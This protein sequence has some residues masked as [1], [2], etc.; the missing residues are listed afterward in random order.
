MKRENKVT[1][2]E[3]II[4]FTAFGVGYTASVYV[5]RY[6]GTV[7]STVNMGESPAPDLGEFVSRYKGL[8]YK[9]AKDTAIF[10]EVALAQMYVEASDGQGNFGKGILALNANNYFG[11]KADANWR[12][13]VYIATDSAGNAGQHWRQYASPEDSI[14][15]YYDFMTHDPNPYNI[16]LTMDTTDK[17]IDAIARG[18]YAGGA[19]GYPALLKAVVPHMHKVLTDVD[20]NY[21]DYK[22]VVTESVGWIG[23]ILFTGMILTMMSGRKVFHHAK[24]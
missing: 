20:D 1:L 6:K 15:D 11:I 16:D 22:G 14:N 18:G 9:R 12:G 24:K 7:T 13:D 23:G 19:P 10:P 4:A 5:N 3:I 17:Q 21:H 2:S 8:F